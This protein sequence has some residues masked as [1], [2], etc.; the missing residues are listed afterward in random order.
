MRLLTILVFLI[1][2]TK[3]RAQSDISVRFDSIMT[4][5]G[6]QSASCAII[7]NENVAYLSYGKK[8]K[9]TATAPDSATIYEIGSITKTFTGA[10][11][12]Q[13]TADSK[14]DLTD[15]LHHLVFQNITWSEQFP[16]TTIKELVTHS[17]GLPRIPGN[18]WMIEN[19]AVNDPY[20]NYNLKNLEK[21]II[22]YTG[23]TTKSTFNYSNLGAGIIGH[24]LEKSYNKSY[25]QLLQEYIFDPLGM[26]SSNSENIDLNTCQNIALP[27]NQ[28]GEV[29]FWNFDILAS[30]GSIKSSCN[31]LVKYAKAHWEDPNIFS[32]ATHV[33]SKYDNRPIGTFWL[34]NTYKGKTLVGHAGATGGSR[35]SILMI[36]DQKMAVIL[37]ATGTADVES[38][39]FS[40]LPTF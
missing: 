40:L 13:A 38:A 4:A 34:S 30:A 10:L 26:S 29:S 15:S 19:F 2:T 31:D 5:L 9:I 12:Q 1:S 27:Y 20:A 21:F 32:K 16:R 24:V 18:L 28:N 14:I 17:S 39:A 6:V 11:V 23:T 33:L 25:S 37:L 8:S 3:F 35:S 7:N 36:P 22:T